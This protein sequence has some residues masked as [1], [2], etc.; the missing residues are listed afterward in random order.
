MK[1]FDIDA[2][3]VKSSDLDV[4]RGLHKTDAIIAVLKAVCADTYLSGQSG[5]EYLEYEQFRQ[6][7]INLRFFGFEHPVYKQV[8]PGFLPKMSAID[9]LFNI[10]PSANQIITSSGVIGD[11]VL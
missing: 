2:E 1:C 7:N 11:N 10:G 8:F 5:M 6:N 9:L 3:I 4:D